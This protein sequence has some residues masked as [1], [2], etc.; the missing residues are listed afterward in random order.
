MTDILYHQGEYTSASAIADTVTVELHAA[1]S[2]YATVY[3]AKTTL[4]QNGIARIKG[5]GHLGQSYYV[6]LKHRNHVETWSATPI[7]LKVNTQYN[8]TTSDSKAFGNNQ[9][10][11]KNGVYALY[12][13]DMNQDG[14]IYAFDY[15]VIDPDISNG[16]SGYLSTDLNGDGSVDAFDYVILDPN[17]YSGI[18]ASTP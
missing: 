9:V 13:G 1:T 10:E 14:A 3:S 15:V 12:S 4:L 6:V 8:F 11:V 2:P 16:S 5:Y 7:T 18:G 17:I